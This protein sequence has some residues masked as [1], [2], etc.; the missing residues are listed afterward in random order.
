MTARTRLWLAALGVAGAVA[1]AVVFVA[2][3]QVGPAT[4]TVQQVPTPTVDPRLILHPRA[5]RFVAAFG[6]GF[7]VAGTLDPSIPGANAIRL[8]APGGHASGRL[9]VRVTM[10]GMAMAPIAATLTAHGGGFTG[11]VTL[12]MFGTYRADMTL[13]HA[14]RSVR[15]TAT[16]EIPLPGQ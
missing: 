14:G 5:R 16:L 3:A 1:L 8:A 12:P 7:R 6:P 13:R 4:A 10:P 9:V 2:R 11:R 15:G